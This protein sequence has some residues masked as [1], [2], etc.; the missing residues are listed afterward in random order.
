MRLIRLVVSDPGLGKLIRVR[1]KLFPMAVILRFGVLRRLDVI[2]G[3]VGKDQGTTST[4]LAYTVVLD[5]VF[6]FTERDL[7]TQ[8]KG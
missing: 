8:L 4:C 7:K 1:R 6:Q 2:I 3:L 5:E